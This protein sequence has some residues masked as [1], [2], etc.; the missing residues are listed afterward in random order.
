MILGKRKRSSFSENV[1]DTQYLS[2]GGGNCTALS[3]SKGMVK[4]TS[5]SD[6]S[7]YYDQRAQLLQAVIRRMTRR[8]AEMR[9]PPCDRDRNEAGPSKCGVS[10]LFSW[11]KPEVITPRTKEFGPSCKHRLDD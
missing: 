4:A 7:G 5:T 11:L 6:E 3:C 9:E 2:T 10:G 8:T 1:R